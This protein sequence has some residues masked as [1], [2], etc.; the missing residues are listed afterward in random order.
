MCSQQY[1][2]ILDVGHGSCVVVRDGEH[3]ILVDTGAPGKVLEYLREEKIQRIDAVILSHADSDHIGGLLSILAQNDP[4]IVVG[5][6][7]C[8][9]DAAKG[10]RIWGDLLFHLDDLQQSGDKVTILKPQYRHSV[11][12]GSGGLFKIKFVGPRPSIAFL[13]PGAKGRSGRKITT[14]S[15]SVIVQVMAGGEP[16]LLLPGDVDENACTSFIDDKLIEHATRYLMLPHHG[17]RIA[18]S[19]SRNRDIVSALVD[20]VRPEVVFISNGRAGKFKN[21]RPEVLEAVRA[22]SSSVSIMCSQLSETCSKDVVHRSP[23][24]FSVYSCGA[25]YG[26]SCKGSTRL[27]AER[28][29][30]IEQDINGHVQF[31]ETVAGALC[32]KQGS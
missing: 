15:A 17:G 6:V 32:M 9:A 14:N 26:Y 12:V 22:A 20:I 11:D 31:L 30:N 4:R 27:Y 21:P 8:A 7:H 19:S 25:V 29:F 28:N 13:G 18:A 2:D 24:A 23:S 1:V 5:E 10:T 3:V 16:L